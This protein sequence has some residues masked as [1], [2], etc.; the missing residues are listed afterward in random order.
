MPEPDGSPGLESR[1]GGPPAA[2]GDR[3]EREAEFTRRAL[4]EAGWT[5]PVVLAVTLPA[6]AYGQSTHA[7]HV[8]G[9]HADHTDHSD[10]TG[11]GG[12]PPVPGAIHTDHFDHTDHADH[13][14]AHLDVHGDTGHAD[15]YTN[16][17]HVDVHDDLVLH[18]DHTDGGFHIDFND[19]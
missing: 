11:P 3:A 1:P 16:P 13:A 5:A 19:G 14:D 4:L 18:S 7:D 6:T 10:A 17:N 2:G 12:R 8:D 15:F 9:L